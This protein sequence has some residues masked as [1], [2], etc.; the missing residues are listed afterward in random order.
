MSDIKSNR[1]LY[2][3]YISTAP[4]LLATISKLLL[5][6]RNTGIAI[7]KG[8]RNIFEF[9]WEELITD[10][11]VPTP[12]DILGLEI[13]LGAPPVVPMESTPVQM[14]VQKKPPPPP[15]A[16]APPPVTLPTGSGKFTT[17]GHRVHSGQETLYK[18][19]R[20]SIHLLTELLTLKMKA[21]LESVSGKGGLSDSSPFFSGPGIVSLDPCV[22]CTY[23][24]Q[25]YKDE[26]GTGGCHGSAVGIELLS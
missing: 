20:Q 16:P 9:T 3:Q 8:I 25:V 7:P 24:K 14:H 23:P 12:S 11:M 6:C 5:V 13:S 21:M 2:L 10:P 4:K 15:P 17:H 19:Q 18:F 26:L 1:E 22:Y